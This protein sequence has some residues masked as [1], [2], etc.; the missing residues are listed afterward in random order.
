MAAFW[1]AILALAQAGG[2]WPR[3]RGPGGDG[4]APAEA[5]PPAE[6]GE[7]RNVAWKTA[8][9]GRGRSSPVL[10]GGRLFA[11]FARERG[12]RRTR[13]G[14]D[15]MQVAD[16]VAL[17]AAAVDAS[18]GRIVWETLLREV[19]RPDP[20]H[21]LNS[22]ATPTPAVAPGRLFCD[23][24]GW[25]TWCLDPETGKVLWEKRIPLDHQV[26]PG[27]SPVF[28]EGLLVLVRDGRD[29]QF[30]I[31]LDGA[32]GETVWKTDRPPIRTGHPNTRKSFS[33]P[34]RIEAAGR[35]QLVAVG[36]HWIASYDPRTGKEIWRLR[37]GDG[38]SIGS[39]PVFGSGRVYFSTGCMRPSLL[40]VRAEGEGELPPSAVAWRAEKGAPVMSSPI[41]AG[42]LLYWTSDEGILT[43]ADARTGEIRIQARLGE[44]HL[45]SPILA[46][47]RLYFFGRDGRTTVIR[48]GPTFEKLAE[49]RI[50]G[51][52]I[53]SPAVSGKALF[54]RTDTHLYRLERREP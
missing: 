42:D 51:T 31:A 50:E 36:P 26:G 3:F 10:H 33:T 6:W 47:G 39:V 35:R 41:L 24:G 12:V 22:W 4:V 37:H 11:T 21:W 32:T 9:P 16:H 5:D 40:A 30:V 17:G 19:D 44:A 34:I 45:A 2:D 52:V 8:L 7:G 29:A 53:A 1:A 48:P 13:I 43:A 27:S 28:E 14:P 46:A 15:D 25:G 23:F 38:F 20:V 18:S 54:L 49:N